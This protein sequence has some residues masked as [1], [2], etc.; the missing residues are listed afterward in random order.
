M[1]SPIVFY[2]TNF[3]TNQFTAGT[4]ADE[5]AISFQSVNTI[6]DVWRVRML[7]IVNSSIVL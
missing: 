2:F 5:P 6:D 7:L 3:L 1:T 4:T